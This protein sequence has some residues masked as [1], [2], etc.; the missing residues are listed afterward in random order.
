MTSKSYIDNDCDDIFSLLNDD[1]LDNL[2]KDNKDYATFYCKEI[3]SVFVYV[4]YIN[5][6]NDMYHMKKLPISIKNNTIPK[7]DLVNIINTHKYYNNTKHKLLSILQYNI[8][9]TPFDIIHFLKDNKKDYSF[10][11]IKQNIDTIHWEDT[12]SMFHNLNGL[13]II[14]NEYNKKQRKKNQTKKITIGIKQKKK[15]TRRHY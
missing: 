1:L 11:K 2:E 13:Y 10:L 7:F 9:L 14:Y 3:K 5:K 4:L 15:R 12:I 6:N 8:S